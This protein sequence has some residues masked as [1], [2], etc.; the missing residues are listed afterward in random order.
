MSEA[1]IRYGTFSPLEDEANRL[2]KESLEGV[3]SQSEKSD[4][5]TEWKEIDRR[6]REIVPWDGVPDA[7]IRRG[8]YHRAPNTAKPYLNSREGVAPAMRILEATDPR[9][10]MDGYGYNGDLSDGIGQGGSRSLR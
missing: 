1:R 2:I 4:I 9:L 5:L 6:R 8:M 10:E 3:T 7:Q